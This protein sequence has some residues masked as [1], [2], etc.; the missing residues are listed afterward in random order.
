MFMQVFLGKRSDQNNACV[1]VFY[2]SFRPQF[3]FY[4]LPYLAQLYP[5]IYTASRKVR[6]K[7]NGF[8]KNNGSSETM[9]IHLQSVTKKNLKQEGKRNELKNKRIYKSE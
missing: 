9:N 8:F 3:I 6:I 5:L 2:F 7:T 4:S 1:H